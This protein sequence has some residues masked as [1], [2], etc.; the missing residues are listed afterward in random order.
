MIT[1][2]KYSPDRH[3]DLIKDWHLKWGLPDYP[4]ELLPSHGFVAYDEDNTVLF[5]Y[6][7]L[8]AA[9]IREGEKQTIMIDHFLSTPVRTLAMK[10]DIN[11]AIDK[12]MDAIQ[13]YCHVHDIKLILGWSQNEKVLQKAREHGC[14]TY[15]T[16]AI[17][18]KF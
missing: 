4:W 3:L 13:E 14:Q 10:A 18:R 15:P 1:V 16:Q 6:R 11:T 8:V 2:Q 5:R 9:F 17:V 12:I 7:P